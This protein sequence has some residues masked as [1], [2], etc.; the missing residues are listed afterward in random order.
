MIALSSVPH[1]LISSPPTPYT[2]LYVNTHT[3][4]HIHL[5][6]CSTHYTNSYNKSSNP[7]AT[8]LRLLFDFSYAYLPHPPLSSSS[9]SPPAPPPS[10]LPSLPLT[11]LPQLQALAHTH[12]HTALQAARDAAFEKEDKVKCRNGCRGVYKHL[13]EVLFPDGEEEEEDEGQINQSLSTHTHTHTHLQPSRPINHD[14]Q[15]PMRGWKL[16]LSEPLQ[17]EI[18]D[19]VG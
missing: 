13:H 8:V 18:I 16:L 19:A 14:A 9:S 7:F 5:H 17:R 11:T 4:T 2:H 1:L 3:N 10:S 12:K 6:L 15:S